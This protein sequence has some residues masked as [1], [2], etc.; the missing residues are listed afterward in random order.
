[1]YLL[2]AAAM[3]RTE[4]AAVARYV[5]HSRERLGVL[6]VREGVITLE[7]MYFADEVRPMEGVA[8]KTRKGG[9]DKRQLDRRD[10]F[11]AL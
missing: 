8:P 5:F 7:R 2:L 9:L 3:E 6:R 11:H 4:L 1:M 10:R